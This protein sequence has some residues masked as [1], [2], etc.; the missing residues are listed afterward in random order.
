M[1]FSHTHEQVLDGSKV[2]TTRLVAPGDRY[3]THPISREIVRVMDAGGRV[4]YEV[5]K[6][7]AAQPGRGKEAVCRIRIKRILKNRLRDMTNEMVEQ[8]GLPLRA[9][10]GVA[11]EQEPGTAAFAELWDSMHGK[12]KADPNT[13]GKICY[14]WAT[15]TAPK[16][17]KNAKLP[18][19][20][21]A[22][23]TVWRL[24][25]ERVQPLDSDEAGDDEDTE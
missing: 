1:L 15:E 5:G 13:G 23:P 17:P 11:G 2:L 25:F 22:N 4:K 21:V 12:W 14:P 8:E 7:Y 16:P 24:W 10:A 6:S 3:E 20:V 18:Y 9:W 19:Q